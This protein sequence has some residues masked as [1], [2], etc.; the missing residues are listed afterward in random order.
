LT[1]LR[2]AFRELAKRRGFSSVVILLLAVGIG[3]ASAMYSL[4]NQ[5]ILEPLPVHEPSELVGIKAPGLKPGSTLAGLALR[6]GTDPLFSY[7]MFRDLEAE[8]RSLSEFAGVAGHYDF[9]ANAAYRSGATYENGIL[10]S[11]N[12]FDVLKVKPW[13]GRLIS[14]TTTVA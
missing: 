3:A 14:R 7:P 13:L 12:Y 5:V 6:Q 2:F 4:L 11:G 1:P 10:V 9:I 8:Q